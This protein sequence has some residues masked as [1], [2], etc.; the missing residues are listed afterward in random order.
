MT[1]FHDVSVGAAFF[2]LAAD[3][4]DGGTG[5][6][7]GASGSPHSG[8]ELMEARERVTTKSLRSST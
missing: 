2:I 3:D 7:A 6:I 4:D 8:L 1:G 5:A